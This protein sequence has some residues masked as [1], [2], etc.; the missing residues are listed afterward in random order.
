MRFGKYLG[1]LLVCA[2]ILALLGG[3]DFIQDSH[4]H[5]F[6]KWAVTKA[7]SCVDEGVQSRQCEECG[8]METDKILANGHTTVKDAAVSA[9]CT[10]DGLTEGSHC[11][12][13]GQVMVAQQTISA[14]GH[15]P[16]KDYPIA[17]TCTAEGLSEGSH[18]ALCGVLIVEQVA[19]P[20]LGHQYENISVVLEANCSQAGIRKFSCV[21]CETSYV[22]SYTTTAHTPET[23]PAVAPGCE[24]DGLTEGSKCKY[25]NIV[26]TIQTS[27]PATGHTY[28]Q[29]VVVLEATC[30]QDGVLRFNC[31][32][33]T[34]YYEELFPLAQKAA[35]QIQTEALQYVGQIVTFD[36]FGQ[37]HKT[38]SGFVYTADGQI[39]TSFQVIDGAYSAQITINGVVYPI[40]GVLAY[41]RDIDLAILKIAAA[42]LPT[43]NVCT[44]PVAVGDV[45]FAITS[46]R[47]TSVTGTQGTITFADRVLG[48][49]SFVQHDAAITAENAG[50]PLINVYGEV[51]G[52]NTL[53]VSDAGDLNFAVFSREIEKLVYGE[54]L[55][56]DAFYEKECVSAHDKLMEYLL[57][58]GTVDEAGNYILTEENQTANAVMTYA[59]CWDSQNNLLSLRVA[60][61]TT[62]GYTTQLQMILTGD[63]AQMS[64]SG[65][66]GVSGEWYNTASGVFNAGTFYSG[67]KLDCTEYAGLESVKDELLVRYR[68]AI[69]QGISWLN[70]Y[71]PTRNLSFTAADLGF[72]N[73]T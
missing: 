54:M 65:A 38:G 70:R 59:L 36:K 47:G 35:D 64:Y 49:I 9:T 66:Y 7:P 8:Y 10:G 67:T 69:H 30:L 60:I 31:K 57:A 26:L 5:S 62:S 27:V 50:S 2:G 72:T 48:G 71:L 34:A 29:G 32:N 15:A 39:I 44:S 51:I 55:T 14:Y 68:D 42:N 16:L 12:V 52:I 73:Y 20:A 6:S 53:S 24:T 13:C 61:V 23:V 40:A 43:A 19:E 46:N 56:M 45:V 28:N 37:Q 4:T 21:R 33:C 3:C 18:C 25:C 17:P 11:S 63:P 1:V 22:E 41:D 58:N